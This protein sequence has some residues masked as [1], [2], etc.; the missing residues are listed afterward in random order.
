MPEIVVATSGQEHL[1]LIDCEDLSFVTA[2]AWRV[3]SRKRD[4]T[5]Y[6]KQRGA[7][8]QGLH[9]LL[10]AA[11]PGVQVDHING[12]GLDN[13]RCNLRLAT[14][15]QNAQNRA[16][17]SDNSSGLKGVS[18]HARSGNAVYTANSRTAG[19]GN[20]AGRLR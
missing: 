2:R 5:L 19:I 1:I 4:K 8:G 20:G 14:P 11:P 9:C 6:V 15:A 18:W 3:I 16:K 7:N 17:R 13:R 10:L 12:N